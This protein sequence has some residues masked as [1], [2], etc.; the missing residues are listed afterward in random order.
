MRR[1]PGATPTP[2]ACPL[3]ADLDSTSTSLA[4]F[5]LFSWRLGQASEPGFK[6]I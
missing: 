3:A 4:V 6:I 5:Y 2:T 1:H